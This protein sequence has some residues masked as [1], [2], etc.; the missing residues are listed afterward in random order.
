MSE[1][2]GERGSAGARSGAAGGERIPGRA[3]SLR[4]A[5][6]PFPLEPRQRPARVGAAVGAGVP[7]GRGEQP[8]PRGTTKGGRCPSRGSGVSRR[9]QGMGQGPVPVFEAGARFS[10][11]ALGEKSGVSWGTKQPKNIAG[12]GDP[13]GEGVRRRSSSGAAG[14][15]RVGGFVAASLESRQSVACGSRAASPVCS[16][17]PGAGL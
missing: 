1:R 16:P 8:L 10:P 14:I 6:L 11:L 12:S 5:P 7:S 17:L 13:V 4:G 9:C 2:E 15:V 3:G